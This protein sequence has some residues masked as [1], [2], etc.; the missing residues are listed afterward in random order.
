VPGDRI[1]G[2]HGL[3]EDQIGAS[4]SSARARRWR[5]PP[6]RSRAVGEQRVV[7]PGQPAHEVVD[8]GAGTVTISSKLARAP[9]RDVVPNAAAQQRVLDTALAAQH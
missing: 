2:A 1:D 8:R 9:E 7:A 4:R 5:C 3:V 6:D